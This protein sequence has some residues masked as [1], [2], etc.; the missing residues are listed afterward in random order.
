MGKNFAN[1]SSDPSIAGKL[2]V[3]MWVACCGCCASKDALLS[4]AGA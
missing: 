3:R 1:T 4:L 2:M